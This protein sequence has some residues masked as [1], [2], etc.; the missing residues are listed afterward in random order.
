MEPQ[1]TCNIWM[2]S[3][4]IKVDMISIESHV[5]NLFSLNHVNPF[6]LQALTCKLE[7]KLRKTSSF[8]RGQHL[9]LRTMW[10][11]CHSKFGNQPWDET[12]NKV[13]THKWITRPLNLSYKERTYLCSKYVKYFHITH[14]QLFLQDESSW[15]VRCF[16]TKTLISLFALVFFTHY[17]SLLND[18]V[19]ELLLFNT[20]GIGP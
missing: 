10:N 12:S 18:Y 3:N 15:H 11:H 8:T 14:W 16:S 1:I 6:F 19:V 17:K 13:S 7:V 4:I 20:Y 2:T 9:T 5:V